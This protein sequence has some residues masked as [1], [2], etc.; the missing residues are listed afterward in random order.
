M[1]RR[2][3]HSRIKRI[4]TKKRKLSNVLS[5]GYIDDP[6]AITTGSKV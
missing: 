1:I 3:L 4:G 5:K 2:R 6:E